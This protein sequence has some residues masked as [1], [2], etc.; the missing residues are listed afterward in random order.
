MKRVIAI[1]AVMSL[2]ASATASARPL[3]EIRA[4]ALQNHVVSEFTGGPRSLPPIPLPYATGFEA[5]EFLLGTLEPHATWSSS[6]VN[7]DWS[8]I[9][10]I[11]PNGGAQH[12]RL[13]HNTDI[14]PPA[15]GTY[16]AK[17]GD[18]INNMPTPNPT[19]VHSVS[20]DVSPFTTGALAGNGNGY[21]LTAGQLFVNGSTFFT[22][23]LFMYD[24]DLDYDYDYD[25][26]AVL[27]DATCSG[28]PAFVVV[29]DTQWG[30]GGLAGTYHNYRMEMDPTAA[31]GV[32]GEPSD[33]GV[34]ASQVKY[35]RDNV[36][37]YSGN[38]PFGFTVTPIQFA[39]TGGGT[40]F[41]SASTGFAETGDFDNVNLDITP[42]P[43][44]L[45]LLGLGALALI[46]RRR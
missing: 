34:T 39:N 25:D 17:Y 19:G 20:A 26:I 10:G 36:L 7:N 30:D 37:I 44:S 21:S 27:D 6:F 23:R 24:Y 33:I 35:Y 4:G 40:R 3:S 45:A 32:G 22:A 12:L 8:V 41:V 5:P 28:A 31:C 13:Q 9:S 11:N 2:V 1:A 29:T 14:V 43:G 15:Q 46:R 18:G 16:L 38:F 42:E